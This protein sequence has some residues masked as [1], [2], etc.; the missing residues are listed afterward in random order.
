MTALAVP[1]GPPTLAELVADQDGVVSRRQ[2]RGAGMSEDQWQW[3]LDTGRWQAVLRGVAVTHSGPVTDRQ[4]SWAAVLFARQGSYLSAD[5]ALIEQGMALPTPTVLHV[6]VP[7]SRQMTPQVFTAAADEV[8]EAP[9]RVRPHRMAIDEAWAHPVRTPPVLRIAPAALH[10]AAWAPTARAGEWRLAAAV[11][12][13]L[14]R[15]SE[16]RAALAAMP[17]LPRHALILTVLDDVEVGAH[18][19]SELDFLRFLRRNKLPAPDR[20]QRLVRTGTIC[21]LDA[22]WERQR[23]AAELDGA[24]HRLVGN[25]DADN[26]RANAVV[27][28]ERH[29]RLLLL[30]FTAGNLRHD[31]PQVAEQLRA[32][33]L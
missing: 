24:H 20:L 16:L 29:D 27:V 1:P 23:V 10:A 11:Q 14:V 9:C 6:A 31:G 4:R 26:L 13:R 30:R 18:A 8:D 25:W 12:Q 3:R 15:P 7:P 19:T 33:L 21:Y 5:A 22:M 32:V 2:A 28:A 17:N